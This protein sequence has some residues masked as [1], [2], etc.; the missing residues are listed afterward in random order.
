MPDKVIKKKRKI[1]V[2]DDQQSAKAAKDQAKFEAMNPP[3]KVRRFIN[4]DGD[5]VF[6]QPL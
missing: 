2:L 1:I 6:Y 4:S 5:L 3:K